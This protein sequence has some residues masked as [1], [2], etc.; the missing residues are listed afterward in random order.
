MTTYTRH[1]GTRDSCSLMAALCVTHHT[2]QLVLADCA[3]KFTE[4]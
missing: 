3:Q 4:F 1:A 2:M